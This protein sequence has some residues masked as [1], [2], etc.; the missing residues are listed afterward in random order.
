MHPIF[1]Q[2][3]DAIT[4]SKALLLLAESEKWDEFTELATQ[5]QQEISSI[6]LEN[7]NLSDSDNEQLHS[8]ITELIALNEQLEKSCINQRSEAADALQKIRK[9]NKVSQAY[10][11]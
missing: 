10:S 11:Q 5:R 6:N 3:T 4:K 7:L 8:L 9:G 1:S 2:V